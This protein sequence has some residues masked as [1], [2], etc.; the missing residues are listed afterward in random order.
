MW[1]IRLIQ[2]IVL[3]CCMGYLSFRGNIAAVI[4]ISTFILVPYLE[5]RRCEMSYKNKEGYSDPTAG[6]AVQAAGRMP[7]HIYNDYCLLNNIAG[8]LGL[9]VAVIREKKTGKEW[10]QRR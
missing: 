8:R 7:T 1:K 4:M 10:P 6:K 2:T 9:E 5:E 3:Y